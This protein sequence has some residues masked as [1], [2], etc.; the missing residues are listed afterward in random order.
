MRRTSHVA[1][2]DKSQ[3]SCIKKN[4]TFAPPGLE[5]VLKVFCAATPL[6]K[7]S[8]LSHYCNYFSKFSVKL[9]EK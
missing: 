1:E 9:D 2:R 7:T 3:L 8:S 6:K 5:D 4:P